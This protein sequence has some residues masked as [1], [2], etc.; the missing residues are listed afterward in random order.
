MAAT[1]HDKLQRG[2]QTSHNACPHTMHCMPLPCP[3]HWHHAYPEL[4]TA[5]KA[6][7]YKPS[8]KEQSTLQ[9]PIPQMTTRALLRQQSLQPTGHTRHTNNSCQTSCRLRFPSSCLHARHISMEEDPK[10]HPKN[11]GA[12]TTASSTSEHWT[13]GAANHTNNTPPVQR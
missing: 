3:H 1:S 12:H 2:R 11:S 7:P 4:R 8:Y 10:L 6:Q 5:A 9:L 13:T